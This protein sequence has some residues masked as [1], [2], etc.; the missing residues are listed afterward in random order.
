MRHHLHG[1]DTEGIGDASIHF[2][3]DLLVREEFAILQ[4]VLGDS[5]LLLKENDFKD[6][7]VG[8]IVWKVLDCIDVVR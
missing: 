2:F 5:D 3:H 8:R 7:L 6:V 4:L 1:N